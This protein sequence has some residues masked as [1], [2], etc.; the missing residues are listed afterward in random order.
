MGRKAKAKREANKRPTVQIQHPMRAAPNWPLL[1]LSILGIVLASYLT[2]TD[3]AGNHVK[4]CAV[5]SGCDVV[6]S[7]SWSRLLGFPTASWGLLA[8]VCLAATAFIK[9]ADQHWWTAWGISFFG[10]LYSLYLTT[11]SLTILHAACPY[12]LTSLALMTSIF[13][14]TSLQRPSKMPGFAWTR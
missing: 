8:Y 3:W 1:A 6:L 11:V 12:C 10:V 7:S 5:G 2:Y 9:R 4:G 14:L 13:T